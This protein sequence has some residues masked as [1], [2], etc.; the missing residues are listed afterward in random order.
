MA[1]DSC[2]NIFTDSERGSVN[3]D[4]AIETGSEAEAGA[5]SQVEAES[6]NQGTSLHRDLQAR[7]I[8][9]IAIGGALGTG[10]LVGTGEALAMAG[11]AAVL[12]TYALLG[13]LVYVVMTAV[14]EMAAWI[15]IS[16]FSGYAT[17]FCHPSLGFCIGWT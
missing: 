10:L 13:L 4:R 7:H 15:P 5:A 14:A 8:T 3:H 1:D 12:I 2:V 6:I 17:R 11:P 16:G 9:M